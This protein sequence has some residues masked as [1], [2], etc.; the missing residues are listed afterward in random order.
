MLQDSPPKPP[1][2]K[3]LSPEEQALLLSQEP[4]YVP[5]TPKSLLSYKGT[6]KLALKKIKG[7]QHTGR[8]AITL[9]ASQVRPSDQANT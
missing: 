3:E 6:S 1:Q 7:Q 2:P 5:T 4:E 9:V 8:G